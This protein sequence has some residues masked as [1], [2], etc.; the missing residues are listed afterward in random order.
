MWTLL[1]GFTGSPRSWSRVV[2]HAEL[3]QAPLIPAL[4]GHGSDCQS[5]GI[6][7]FE[8]EVAR[9]VSCASD[10]DEPRLLCGYSMGARVALG[11]LADSPDLFDAALLIGVHP[12]LADEAARAERRAIDATRAQSLRDDGVAAFVAA[13]EELPLF[14]SQRKLSREV[15]AD[16]QD[17]RLGQDAEGLARALEVLG[18]GEMP[19]YRSAMASIEI[20]IT[21]MTGALDAKF[22]SMATALASEHAHIEA[23]VV[24]G[25]GH[26]VVLEAPAAVAAALKRAQEKVRAKVRA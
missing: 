16:Q 9:L 1:H 14:A 15:L 7:S 4:V 22:S 11:M 5:R 8:N 25:V 18:L 2:A 21:L 17:I 19:D 23:D 13:W 26:N 24:D 12:G 10:A 6:E 3:A 20:P